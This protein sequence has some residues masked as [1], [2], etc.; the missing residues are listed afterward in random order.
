MSVQSGPFLPAENPAIDQPLRVLLTGGGG[1]GTEA[2]WR[3]LSHNYDVWV[4]DADSERIHPVVPRERVRSIPFADDRLFVDAMV[5]LCRTESIDVLV[6]GVDEELLPL[7]RAEGVLRP[8]QVMIPQR[9]FIE[10]MLDKWLF[11][12]ALRLLEIE[13]PLTAKLGHGDEWEYFPCIVKPRHGRGSRGVSII[14]DRNGLFHFRK[15]LGDRESAFVVQQKLEGVEFTVQVFSNRQGDLRVV[16]PARVGLKRGVTISCETD[17][18]PAVIEVCEAIHSRLEASGCYNVQGIL[19]RDGR[20]RPFEI[21]PRVST[22]LCLSLAAGIDPI[23]AFLSGPSSQA[24][25]RVESTWKLERFWM[26]YMVR[27]EERE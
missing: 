4:A 3:L 2:M 9:N 5:D 27:V 1:A 8:T 19:G 10:T 20:F 14:D 25:G 18:V 13:V 16:V 22:T 6:P 26:N 7:S 21:N 24:P 11:S 12:E 23:A 17:P 15:A